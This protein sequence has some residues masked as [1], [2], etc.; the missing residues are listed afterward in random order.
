MARFRSLEPR[1]RWPDAFS[2]SRSA[3]E[4]R[5]QSSRIPLAIVDGPVHQGRSIGGA[6][7]ADK[8]SRAG[9]HASK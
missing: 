8:N 3:L 4:S 9:G 7:A 6:R 1:K 5:G 2:A